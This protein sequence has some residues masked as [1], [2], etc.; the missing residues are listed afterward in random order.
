LVVPRVVRV[1]GEAGAG[2][3]LRVYDGLEPSSCND[4]TC[5][6]CVLFRGGWV[7]LLGLGCLSRFLGGRPVSTV[8]SI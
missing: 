1:L 8:F 2:V 5:W 6:A 3:V 4:S 7:D